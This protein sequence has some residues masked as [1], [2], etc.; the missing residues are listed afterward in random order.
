MFHQLILKMLSEGKTEEAYI[1]VSFVKRVQDMY[2]KRIQQQAKIEEER[3]K[4]I[5]A[6]ADTIE[7]IAE[8]RL[9]KSTYKLI[10]AE[11]ALK[12][13]AAALK[14]S[15]DQ[16]AQLEAKLKEDLA[17]NHSQFNEYYNKYITAMAE[18][19]DLKAQL[20]EIS[21]SAIKYYNMYKDERNMRLETL[22]RNL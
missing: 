11:N 12:E 2:E 17:S 18:N 16:I 15:Q 9:M 4:C 6:T 14:E 5:K 22:M 13:S 21:K 10:L 1:I 3:I 8:D 20:K 7:K 19:D